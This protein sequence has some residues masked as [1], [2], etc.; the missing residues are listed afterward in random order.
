MRKREDCI[1]GDGYNHTILE[2]RLDKT[3]R[4]SYV[5]TVTDHLG[6]VM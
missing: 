1:F 2:T 4:Q 3:E 5:V 6:P